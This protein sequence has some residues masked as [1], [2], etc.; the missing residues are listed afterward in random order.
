MEMKTLLSLDASLSQRL[1]L[2]ASHI[3]LK[4]LAAFLAHSGDSWFWAAGL[5][6]VWLLTA[7]TDWHVRSALM[8]IGVVVLA[9]LVLA[10][11]FTIRR[12]RPEGEWGAIYR[13][14]DPH[15]FPSGHAARAFMLAVMALALGPAWFGALVAVWAPLVS[16]A[17]VSMGVHY[18]SDVVAGMLVGILAG[19]VMVWIAPWLMTLTSFLF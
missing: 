13:N 5:G 10:I 4:K 7:G 18:L 11:K 2:D 14:T 17:R 15:S 9:F 12:K 6:L 3:G 8:L 16:L 19:L 1:R